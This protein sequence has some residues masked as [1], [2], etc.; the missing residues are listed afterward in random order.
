MQNAIAMLIASSQ[1]LLAG[2]LGSLWLRDRRR[3]PGQRS[4]HVGHAIAALL[5][6]GIAVAVL[7]L[8]LLT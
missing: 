3:P 2:T 8:A 6:L 5:A 1:L 7:A 4:T